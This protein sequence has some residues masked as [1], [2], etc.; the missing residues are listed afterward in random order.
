MLS[1][2]TAALAVLAL[3]TSV[4]S[5]ILPRQYAAGSC[6]FHL[7]EH[8]SCEPW[9]SNLYASV[10]LLDNNKNTIYTTP[11]DRGIPIN[12]K[13]GGGSIQGPLP[14]SIRITGEH[15]GDYIQFS[16]GGDSWTSNDGRCSAGGWDPRD[17]NSCDAKKQMDC[18][19]AC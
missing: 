6:C 9:D 2:P 3:S 7:I 8:Q 5:A 1:L 12:D 16:Y 18:C 10:T 19:F 17:G 11:G 4:Q 13:D 15:Q 14:N